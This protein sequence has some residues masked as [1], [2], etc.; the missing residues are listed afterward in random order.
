MKIIKFINSSN[1][2]IE[3]QD[4]YKVKRHTTYQNFRIGQVKNPYD[5]LVFGIGY[6][7][8]G[9]Y[10]AKV[11]YRLTDEY[12]SWKNLLARCYSDK[13]RYLH[14]SYEDC[15]MYE[16]WLNFQTYAK[17]Y[18]VN[19]Y[20][21]GEGRMHI[22]KDILVKGNKIYSPETCIFVPQ[23]I[24][25]IFSTRKS[26]RGD[27]PCGVS[28]NPS[29]SYSVTCGIDNGIIENLGTYKTVED[30]FDAYK[31]RKEQNIKD[32]ADEYKDRIPAKLYDALYSWVVEI[33]D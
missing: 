7:G 27:L 32:V 14:P 25:E 28:R 6:Y 21:I 12:N 3:F 11:N 16:E 1:I 31:I 22:D 8:E 18:H 17:W 33:T 20:D 29:G 5:K 15:Y 23:R 4:A 24:N 10:K 26:L 30:A 2:V 19:W 13:Y 9:E